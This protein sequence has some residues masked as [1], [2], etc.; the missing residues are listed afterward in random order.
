MIDYSNQEPNQRK[1]KHSKAL[2]I[3]EFENFI[4][5]V[6]NCDFDVMLELKDKEKS[7]M[8]AIKV[9]NQINSNL[10]SFN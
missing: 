1:G 8:N 9:I 3:K 10:K 6:Y 4:L 2:D 7:A 5:S